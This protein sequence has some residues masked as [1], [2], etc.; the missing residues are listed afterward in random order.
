M[1]TVDLLEPPKENKC[2]DCG[3]SLR[4]PLREE[5]SADWYAGSEPMRRDP[6]LVYLCPTCSWRGTLAVL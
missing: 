3:A 5:Y 6:R 2:P 1:R 4:P